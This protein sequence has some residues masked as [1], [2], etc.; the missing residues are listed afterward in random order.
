M[1]QRPKICQWC[2]QYDKVHHSCKKCGLPVG[3]TFTCD[4]WIPLLALAMDKN[5]EFVEYERSDECKLQ[6][7]IDVLLSGVNS[8]FPR[9]MTKNR[10]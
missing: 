8:A 4:F 1:H 9:E 10:V 2:N 6:K 5:I 3:N 7:T